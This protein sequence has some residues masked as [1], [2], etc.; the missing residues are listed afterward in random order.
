LYDDFFWPIP[1]GT[2]TSKGVA[3]VS[4]GDKFDLDKGRRIALARAESAAYKE[5]A[6]IVRSHM[7]QMRNYGEVFKRFLEKYDRVKEGNKV[8]I[9][10]VDNGEI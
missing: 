9:K 2:K 5:M 8:Y 7:K 6:D 3:K 1:Y 10:R 4:P